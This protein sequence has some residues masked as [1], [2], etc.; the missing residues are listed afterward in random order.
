MRTMPFAMRNGTTRRSPA[1]WPPRSKR[2]SSRPKPTRT[3]RSKPAST[4]CW[5]KRIRWR[6]DMA[7]PEAMDFEDELRRLWKAEPFT[8]FEIVAAGGEQFEISDPSKVTIS[9]D[10]VKIQCP[11][12]GTW[13]FRTNHLVAV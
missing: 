13:I 1:R 12:G 7:E 2:E 11:D 3:P 6:S 10:V 8:P 5:R 9:A 4:T